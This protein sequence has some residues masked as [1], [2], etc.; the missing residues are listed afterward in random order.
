[1]FLFPFSAEL[2]R[3]CSHHCFFKGTSFWPH[4]SILSFIITTGFSS[5]LIGQPV[6]RM[7]LLR[8]PP[9][10]PPVT[11]LWALSTKQRTVTGNTLLLC[12]NIWHGFFYVNHWSTIQSIHRTLPPA[13]I[14][15]TPALLRWEINLCLAK[16]LLSIFYE[17]RQ[18]LY[19]CSILSRI[20]TLHLAYYVLLLYDLFLLNIWLLAA[21]V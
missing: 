18:V 2:T 11:T 13:R 8:P 7:L 12:D 4:L 10:P 5:L 1:M 20:I 15:A 19:G 3:C 9:H 6:W 16:D 17:P 14:M 21:S